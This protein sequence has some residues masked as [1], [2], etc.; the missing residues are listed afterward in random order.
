MVA[1]FTGLGTGAERGSGNILGAAGLIGNASV[2]RLGEQALLN[3]ATG[4]LI[5]QDRDEFLIG[6]G[7]GVEIA[8]TYNSLGNF[9][10]DNG[11]NWRLSTDRRVYGLT[12]TVNSAGSTVT[13]VS[14]DGTEI[15]YAWN[16]SA[17]VYVTTDGG[18]A[19]DKL[20]YTGSSWVWT[21]GDTQITE[22]Y[23]NIYNGQYRISTQTDSSGNHLTFT[24]TGANLARIATATGEYIHYDWSGSNITDVVTGYT[25]L[26]TGQSKTLTSTR[27]TYDA[28]NRL[29]S[30]TSDLSPNDNSIIDGKSV[31][32]NY[33]YDGT[34]KRVASISET[35]SN[36]FV[37]FTY[38][39]V[40]ADY[41]VS[42][43]TEFGG[44]EGSRT[45]S[46]SY[47][48]ANRRT[49][50]TDALGKAT[51]LSYDTNDNLVSVTYP[52]A[53][54]N[55]AAQV[56][57]YSYNVNGDVASIVDPGGKATIFQYDTNGN[58]VLQ[59]DAAGDTVTRTYGNRNELLTEMVCLE[60]IGPILKR[61]LRGE[62]I[63]GLYGRSAIYAGADH[64]EVA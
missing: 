42:D 60:R 21:D 29:T 61:A 58:V 45:T 54:T 64:C 7:L 4:N 63:G 20:R 12:G 24:Y 40:G 23:A 14:G 50:V 43:I 33:T 31:S 22:T 5:I 55:S 62:G 27:Y 11:D 37:N 28:Y 39:Q 53:Q 19:Y 2:G 34:S 16:A 35:G 9:S 38:V 3:A 10:D 6:R 46:F 47:D 41:R 49:T 26:A 25:D 36:N 52:P 59:R 44:S 8:R 56:V 15:T 17:G 51:V 57:S 18:G 32:I 1:I 48:T 13:R 30:V